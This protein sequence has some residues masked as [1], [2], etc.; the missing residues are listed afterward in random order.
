MNDHQNRN[1]RDFAKGGRSEG[2]TQEEEKKEKKSSV[3]FAG[4]LALE[5]NA[6]LFWQYEEA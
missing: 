2:R 6:A 5:L 3:Y 4:L 1:C